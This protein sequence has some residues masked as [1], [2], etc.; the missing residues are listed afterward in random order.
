MKLRNKLMGLAVAAVMVVSA[1]VGFAPATAH[2]AGAEVALVPQKTT[3]N[4][5]DTVV[6]DVKLTGNTGMTGLILNYTYDEAAFEFVDAK[7]AGVLNGWVKPN[8]GSL[9][10][11]D[12]EATEN[13]TANGTIATLTFT[14][15]A[16]A[17]GVKGFTVKVKDCLDSNLANV[18]LAA[19]DTTVT[20]AHKHVYGEWTVKTEATCGTAGVEVRKCACGEEETREIAATGKHTYGEWTVVKEATCTEAG[21]EE[22]VCS[23]CGHKEQKDIAAKGHVDANGDGKCDVCGKVVSPATGDN[24]SVMLWMSLAV[25]AAAVVVYNKKRINA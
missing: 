2:A 5:G 16:D 4:A 14:A 15:K 23:V 6:V 13:N 25:V 19:K 7:D 12:S 1:A 8:V 21:V 18:T 24:T 9:M 20:I 22:H 10:W 11:K 17:E 3:V